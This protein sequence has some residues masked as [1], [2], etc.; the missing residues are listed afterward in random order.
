[1]RDEYYSTQLLCPEELEAL[2][3]GFPEFDVE[4]LQSITKYDGYESSDTT[5]E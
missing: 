3:C 5:I 2:I 4:N 1:M